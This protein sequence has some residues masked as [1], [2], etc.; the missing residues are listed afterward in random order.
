MTESFNSNKSKHYKKLQVKYHEL[1][2]AYHPDHLP[3]K[4]KLSGE[5]VVREVIDAW[6]NENYTKI[7]TMHEKY[8]GA[9]SH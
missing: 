6:K 9:C 2:A 8:L 5:R 3:E 1:C 7:E 4:D